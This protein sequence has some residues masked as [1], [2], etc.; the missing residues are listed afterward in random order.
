MNILNLLIV[1]IK[2]YNDFNQKYNMKK[3][4]VFPKFIEDYKELIKNYDV[5]IDQTN[6]IMTKILMNNN[7]YISITSPRQSGKSLVMSMLYSFLRIESK[8][9]DFIGEK[10]SINI[11]DKEIFTGVTS[12]RTFDNKTIPESSVL[13]NFELRLFF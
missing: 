12:K 5:H 7:K 11:C 1:S 2:T 10:N 9:C 6:D 4:L 13:Q 3:E 8:P